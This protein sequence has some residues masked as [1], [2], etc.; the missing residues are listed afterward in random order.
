MKCNTLLPPLQ[1]QRAPNGQTELLK[2]NRTAAVQWLSVVGVYIV[3]QMK[4]LPEIL[5]VDQ[6]SLMSW[7]IFVDVFKIPKDTEIGGSPAF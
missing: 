2:V 6:F 7:L 5:E 4:R 3:A 1:G